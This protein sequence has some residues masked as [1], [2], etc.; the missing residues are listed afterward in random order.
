MKRKINCDII[1]FI[2]G[3]LGYGLIEILWRKY[4]HWTM[5][6]TGGVCFVVLYR[7]F[8]KIIDVALWKK[9]LL[10]SGV[11]TIIEFISGCIVNLWYKMNV[12]D[13]SA[14]PGNLF[15]QV[16]MLYSFL[17]GLLTIPI[18]GICNVINR[19]LKF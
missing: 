2:F 15:G 11:I 10:G 7:L 18:V 17:W 5:I 8:S 3:G 9:C 13:Y 1:L 4:T 16:C 19:K 12:W 14:I 6:I